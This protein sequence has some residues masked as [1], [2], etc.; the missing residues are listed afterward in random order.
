VS[1]N[2]GSPTFAPSRP[3]E[4]TQTE[5]DREFFAIVTDQIAT[6]TALIDPLTGRVTGQAARTLYGE[7][8]WVGSTTPWAFPGQYFDT[9]SGLHYNRYRYYDARSGRYVSP[10]PLGLAPA[11]NPHAYPD[12]PSVWAD[13]F[14]LAPTGACSSEVVRYDPQAAARNILE[15]QLREG[16]P[17]TPAGRT[18]TAHAA[19]RI[20]NGGGGRPPVSLERVDDILDNPTRLTYRP[21]NDTVKVFQGRAYVVVSGTGPQHIVTVMAPKG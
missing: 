6:P 19:D 13:P 9:E 5:V 21:D 10:D 12:N 3:V 20:A 17:Q 4:W 16:Y 7:S 18:I 14:G 2:L 8:T 11:P 15:Q 1:L